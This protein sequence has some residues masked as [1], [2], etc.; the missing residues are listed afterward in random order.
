VMPRRGW[1]GWI[2]DHSKVLGAIA[3]WVF[4]ATGGI[5]AL[6]AS[7][8]NNGNNS[9]NTIAAVPTGPG[10]SGN[11]GTTTTGGTTTSGGTGLSGG[12]VGKG[13]N[14]GTSGSSGAGP[15]TS[16]TTSGTTGSNGSSNTSTGTG[17]KHNTG[18]G[19]GNQGTTAQ[20]HGVADVAVPNTSSCHPSQP[21]AANGHPETGITNGTVTIGE[22]ISDVSQLPQQFRP[23]YEGLSAWANLA[24]KSGG[25]CGRKINIVERN[26]NVVNFRSDYQSLASQV[27]AFVSAESLRD[28]D[29]YQSGPPYMPQ[30]KDGNTGEFVPD[31]GGLALAYPRAQSP[32]HA[33]VFGSLSPTLVGGGAYRYMTHSTPGN[34]CRKGGVLYLQEPTG[35]S[36]DQ[37]DIGLA[38]LEAKWG[39]A[40]P[41]NE[42]SAPLEAPEPTYSTIVQQMIADGVNCVFTYADGG[43]NVNLVQAMSQNQVW[44]PS[45]C[46]AARKAANQ[47][48][49][50]VYMP[51]TSADARFVANE[52]ADGNQVTTYFPHVPLSETSNPAVH[53]YLSALAQC[54]SAHAFGCTGSAQ[55]STFSVIGF[56]SG[57]MFGQALASCGSAPTRACVMQWLHNLKNFTAGGLVFP[58]T[59][60]ECTKVKYNGSD[61][62]YKHIF[63]RF[64][65]VRELG[66]PSQGINAFKRI[67]PSSGFAT[68]QLHIVRGSPG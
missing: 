67:Y 14:G 13:G 56:A 10:T 47:C 7:A 1:V 46:S 57:I 68:D 61:Y 30:D 66:S 17:G 63:Y 29:E 20:P 12:A 44:P 51:F 11:T 25:I 48:F 55:P 18:G 26:D 58:I 59:P 5:G 34:K 6:I 28:G 23:T 16:G 41:A 50:L 53:L 37:A 49:E 8:S 3:I 9:S 21:K 60:F 40:L 19:G 4:V 65:V 31:V 2:E 22:I 15:G 27:F 38:A 42:Y 33:G 52:G 45:Q 43:S 62:C 32:Y 39:G 54:D 35:A 36:K 64:A 24:N